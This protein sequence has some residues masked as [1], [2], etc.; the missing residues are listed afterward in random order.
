MDLYVGI[1]GWGDIK[2]ENAARLLDDFLPREP[3]IVV[4]AEL[5]EKQ[6]GVSQVLAWMDTVHQ[7]YQIVQVEGVLKG[8]KEHRSNAVLI[9]AGTDYLSEEIDWARSLDVPVLDLTRA[10]FPVSSSD[11]TMA[12]GGSVVN[13]DAT[14]A[15]QATDTN[16]PALDEVRNA[17]R[18]AGYGAELIEKVEEIMSEYHARTYIDGVPWKPVKEEDEPVEE[19]TPEE[20]SQETETYYHDE[21]KGTYRRKGRRKIKPGEKEVELT[22]EQVALVSDKIVS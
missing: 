5:P 7:D 1:I 21:T 9:V 8:L 22:A 17:L 20:V 2:Y 13:A 15:K 18:D 19:S 6:P 3:E 4:V 14:P 16:P 12:L 11:A 10:L